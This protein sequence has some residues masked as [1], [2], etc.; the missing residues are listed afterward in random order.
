MQ[1]FLF[2]KN[3]PKKIPIIIFGKI[4][5]ENNPNKDNINK[6]SK[7]EDSEDDIEKKFDS[8]KNEKKKKKKKKK[9]PKKS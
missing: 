5:S 6:N 8:D 9:I 7:Y 1:G 2:F 3:F 4:F